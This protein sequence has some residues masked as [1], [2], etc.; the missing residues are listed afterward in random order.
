MML[1]LRCPA[2]ASGRMGVVAGSVVSTVVGAVGEKDGYQSPRGP[3][4]VLNQDLCGSVQDK[5]QPYHGFVS[6]G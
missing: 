4:P 6:Q 5:P 2:F 1:T 3:K